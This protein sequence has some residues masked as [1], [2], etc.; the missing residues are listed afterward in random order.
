MY[1]MASIKTMSEPLD[2]ESEDD[3]EALLPL[4]VYH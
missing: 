2:D 4:N 3:K 1:D